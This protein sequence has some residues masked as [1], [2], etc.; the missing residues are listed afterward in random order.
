M[1]ASARDRART[2]A[3]VALDVDGTLT[4][5]TLFIGPAGEVFKGFSVRDGFGMNLLARAG[6]TVALITARRSE[7]VAAR[8]AELGIGAVV[9]GAKDKA[10]ALAGLC[11][12]HGL[13]LAQ[14]A[15]M[16]DDWPDLGAM[17]SA[18]LAATVADAP[19]PVLDAAHWVA[20]RPAGRGAVREL[21]E[22]V[23][24]A[25]GELAPLLA[26][27]DPTPRS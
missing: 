17:R 19:Q 5:G 6:I 26:G 27:Y 8:A 14:A 11:R 13:T 20:T 9:Q 24:Q 3:L 25:R 2:I 4:D 15:F 10:G 7:I 16:G 18:G 12:D 23:L 21:A 1:T 22:F